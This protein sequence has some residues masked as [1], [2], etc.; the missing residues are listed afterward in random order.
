[1]IPDA[2]MV[3]TLRPGDIP[4]AWLVLGFV[5]QAL[6][7]GRFFVQ[8]LASE[9]R[10]TSVVPG[11]FWWLS[12]GGGVCLLVYALARRDAVIVAGQ[13]AGLAVYARN[14]SLGRRR[15]RD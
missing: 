10:R 13:L 1:M 9:R 8:W 2:S 15:P 12:I 5:G 6:F 3:T 7:A 11:L 14:V 4:P